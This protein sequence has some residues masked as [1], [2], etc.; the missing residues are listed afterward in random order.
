V[1]IVSKNLELLAEGL[2]P[3][4]EAGK[5]TGFSRSFL[6]KLMND[7]ELPFT[8]IGRTRRI[9]RRALIDLASRHLVGPARD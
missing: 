2:L 5:F 7:G 3:V 1:A 6:Y 4:E 9:P 8:K